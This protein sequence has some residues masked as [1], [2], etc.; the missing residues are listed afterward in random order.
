MRRSSSGF[1]L[2]LLFLLPV[3][4]LHSL[5]DVGLLQADTPVRRA[6]QGGH[7]DRF[8]IQLEQDHLVRLL[9]KQLGIDLT[10]RVYSPEQQKLAEF[11]RVIHTG[12]DEAVHFAT[13]S[14]GT[15]TVGISSGAAMTNSAGQYE[16]RVIEIR[17]AVESELR[18]RRER[19]LVRAKGVD[20]LKSSPSFFPAIRSP[21]MCILLQVRVADLLWAIDEKV[22][23]TLLQE[24]AA[25]AESLIANRNR[26]EDANEGRVTPAN[27]RESVLDVAAR[28]DAELSLQFLRRTRPTAGAEQADDE[29]EEQESALEIMVAQR[30]AAKHPRQAYQ[31][32]ESA[33]TRGYPSGVDKV[34]SGIRE[35]DPA[36]AARLAVQIAG[37]LQEADLLAMTGAADLAMQLLQVA[38][39]SQSSPELLS[40]LQYANLFSKALEAGLSF[41]PDPEVNYAP[42]RFSASMLLDALKSMK[43]EMRAFA[44]GRIADIEEKLAQ[45]ESPRYPRDRVDNPYDGPV[46]VALERIAGLPMPLRNS[47]YLSLVQKLAGSGDFGH[48]RDIAMQRF[49]SLQWRRMALHTV[50]RLEIQH[51]IADGR[52][53]EGLQGIRNLKQPSDRIEM[54]RQVL[55]NVVSEQKRET[56]LSFLDQAR[57]I[58]TTSSRTAERNQMDALLEIA[59]AYSQFDP[60]RGIEIVEPF[61]DQFNDLA[62]AAAVLDRFNG[63]YD[64]D[65]VLIL[66]GGSL[67]ELA[68]QII[69]VLAQLAPGDFERVKAGADR[70][71]L[72]EVRVSAY[73]AIAESAIR[74]P[75]HKARYVN[76]EVH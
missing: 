60:H 6:I 10:V 63:E 12:G 49:R 21:E 76:P 45:F 34:I 39:P 38:R 41:S 43:D 71:L 36:M 1:L 66:A 25:D 22:A 70:F 65:G 52:I 5:Q 4:L 35:S 17:R 23:R 27:L 16:I 31:L 33:L 54:V 73:I 3:Q 11:D 55:E 46:N 29:S 58:V 75:L 64:D 40:R 61:V 30:V 62:A 2:L 69:E 13:F 48:A 44:P 9:V 14:S 72:P 74:G 68:D 26:A 32:A 7:I 57:V 67:A 28:Y 24:A 37:R 15:H 53:D 50:D 47:M 18:P 59:L 8:R 42:Q 56:V 20:L 19:E 51:F